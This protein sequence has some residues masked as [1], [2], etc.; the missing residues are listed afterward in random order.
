MKDCTKT[1]SWKLAREKST[2]TANNKKLAN[3][4]LYNK[5]P[6]LCKNC[7]GKLAYT[8]R[9]S[10]FCSKSCA[11][12]LNNRKFPKRTK[13][14]TGNIVKVFVN[15][16]SKTKYCIKC[17]GCDVEF[18]TFDDRRKY[19]KSSCKSNSTFLEN[20]KKFTSGEKVLHNK[21]RRIL[22]FKYGA[23]CSLC[24]WNQINPTTGK[25]PIELDH[26]DGN[27]E[28]TVISNTRLLCPNCHSLQP[29]YKSLNKGNGR[30]SRRVRYQSGKSY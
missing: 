22:I 19:C 25:V 15:H 24:G 29:T 7:G 2:I 8:K 12:T 23:R 6:K 3:I 9:Y 20:V 18:L 26:I 13:T 21:A 27:A 5:N 16:R 28:N 30:Y 11:A 1:E 14:S 17:I 4:E 10:T